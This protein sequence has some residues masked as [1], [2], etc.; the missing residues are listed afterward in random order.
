MND[1]SVT[2]HDFAVRRDDWTKGEFFTRTIDPPGNGEV[3]FRI[4]RYALTSNNISYA[5][6]GDMLGYWKFFPAEDGWGRLPCFAFA[7]VERSAHPDV[8]EGDRYFGYFP[9]ST[10][11]LVVADRV[12]PESLIDSTE[13]RRQLPAAYNRYT[14]TSQDPLYQKSYEDAQMLMQPLFL[15]SWLVDDFL[16]ENDF[17]GAKLIIVTSASS[18]TSIALAFQLK[19]RSLGQVIGLTSPRNMSF[20][21]GVGFYD[22]V[23]SY[24]AIETLD[25]NTPVAMVDMAG[26]REVIGR[27]HRH[28]E[29]NMKYNCTV[30]AT[31]W[32]RGGRDKDLPGA[33]PQFFFAPA[34][35]KKRSDEWG[36]AGLMQRIGEA[37]MPF[38][39]TSD[40]WLKVVRHH[41]Q[42][43]IARIYAQVVAGGCAPNEGQILS[44]WEAS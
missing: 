43:A 21:E 15:T 10:H 42:D 11:L 3:L 7:D 24:D 2:V 40:N 29:H 8:N 28:F 1:R 23:L 32:D 33:M 35:I 36:R 20:V 34:Q 39:R 27:L 44:F 5:V 4:D 14:N 26:D 25:A 12:K 41:G 19:Q 37:W 17:F 9:M 31:H 30:G 6:A 22:Q 38:V 18:K 16:A 13:H